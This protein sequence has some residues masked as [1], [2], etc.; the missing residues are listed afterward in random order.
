[1]G[2]LWGTGN[3]SQGQPSCGVKLTV[4]EQ[5][6]PEPRSKGCP[7]EGAPP[8]PQASVSVKLGRPLK[9]VTPLPNWGLSVLGVKVNVKPLRLMLELFAS[10]IVC[11]VA[12]VP[13]IWPGKVRTY[14]DRVIGSW[15][16]VGL[17]NARQMYPRSSSTAL[18]GQYFVFTTYACP[19][20]CRMYPLVV[21]LNVT[22]SGPPLLVAWLSGMPIWPSLDPS[23]PMS[24]KITVLPLIWPFTDTEPSG[25]QGYSL[26]PVV[27]SIKLKV[28]VTV[29]LLAPTFSPWVRDPVTGKS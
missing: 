7:C 27:G 21:E 3:G 19:A 11:V 29:A 22:I 4:T 10:V 18:A 28:P 20:E 12:G 6:C 25:I 23:S 8:A 15:Q 2:G 16:A 13:K 1:M 5:D 26:R 24:C 17:F 9:S 14:G